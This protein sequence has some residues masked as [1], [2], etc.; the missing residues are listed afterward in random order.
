MTPNIY[1]CPALRCWI[2]ML[3]LFHRITQQ[4]R[5]KH[6]WCS[7]GNVKIKRTRSGKVKNVKFGSTFMLSHQ[8]HQC[9]ISK[10]DN[11]TNLFDFPK[12]EDQKIVGVLDY[13]K[14]SGV[15]DRSSSLHKLIPPNSATAF[16]IFR[17]L[18]VLIFGCKKKLETVLL[19]VHTGCK[20]LNLLPD[21]PDEHRIREGPH[22]F[23]SWAVRNC[24][25]YKS[26]YI[27]IYID[28]FVLL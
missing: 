11:L 16:G 4:D 25:A 9:L 7:E 19:D 2:H 8:Y 12:K 28:T 15:V 22:Q 27:Y 24:V 26:I 10:Q 6:Q 13:L 3:G 18:G 21:I 14:C 17:R 1:P 20:D 23:V 5:E